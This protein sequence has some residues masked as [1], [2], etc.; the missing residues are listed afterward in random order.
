MAGP[1]TN[2]YLM[3]VTELIEHPELLGHDTL[4][5]L[6]R[7]VAQ[8]PYYQAARLLLIEN[9]FLLHDPAFDEELRTAALFVP[10]R[11]VLFNLVESLNYE[12]GHHEGFA[13]PAAPESTSPRPVVTG[14][15]TLD[16]IG[17]FLKDRPCETSESSHLKGHHAVVSPIGDYTAVLE[18]MDDIIEDEIPEIPQAREFEIVL[19]A[20]PSAEPESETPEEENPQQPIKE[21]FFTET[22]AKV[23]IK[24]GNYERALEILSKINLENPRKNA[25]FAD[26]IKFLQKLIYIKSAQ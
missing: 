25:Y 26:Q 8:C 2:K 10:D 23:F 7:V 16:I 4:T 18:N 15:R 11:T 19:P 5:E 21:E 20:K 14:S 17:Q 3:Q 24:Q 13:A 22:L 1:T 12:R 9:L 6:R